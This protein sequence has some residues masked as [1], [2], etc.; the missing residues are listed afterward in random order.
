M[1]KALDKGIEITGLRLL[2]KS[3]GKSGLYLAPGRTRGTRSLKFETR[4]SKVETRKPK[5]ESRGK[6]R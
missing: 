5:L 6:Q 4:K 3:G 1:C 2:E